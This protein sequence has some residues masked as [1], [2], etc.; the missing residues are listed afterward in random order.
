[1][2][3]I[4]IL[5]CSA[6][7]ILLI[8]CGQPAAKRP[9]TDVDSSQLSPILNGPGEVR[10]TTGTATGDTAK[11]RSIPLELT[12]VEVQTLDT[13][14]RIGNAGDLL[15]TISGRGFAFTSSNPVVIAG[16]ERYE[17]TYSNEEG[18]ELYVIIPSGNIQR[19]AAGMAGQLQVINPGVNSKPVSIKQTGNELMRKA[20]TN[21]KA[22]LLFTRFAVE[23]RIVKR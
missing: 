11:P 19:F 14:T 9:A 8:S 10:L 6:L 22:A 4:F 5:T 16:R 2:K 12:S 13:S 23:R 3:K 15:I 7:F 17:N 20:G 1:M 18:S 21:E